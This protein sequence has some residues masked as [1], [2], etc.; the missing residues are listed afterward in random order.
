MN[1]IERK[2]K[3]LNSTNELISIFDKEIFDTFGDNTKKNLEAFN[4]DIKQELLFRVLC[5]GEFN[6]GKSTFLNNFFLQEDILP[7][8][9]IPTTAKITTIQYGE[10]RE[11]IITNQANEIVTYKD[12]IADILQQKV[13]VN[14]IDL[15]K[16]NEVKLNIPSDILKEG[17]V[18]IDT[19]GL[20]EA[21]EDRAR[22]TTEYLNKADAAIFLLNARQ[23][24]KASEKQF[25]EEFIFSKKDL[26]KIFFVINYWDTINEN[27]KEEVLEYVKEQIEKSLNKIQLKEKSLKEIELFTI[28]AKTKENFEHLEEKLFKYLS[29]KKTS[30]ILE[31][32]NV[33]LNTYIGNAISFLEEQKNQLKLKDTELEKQRKIASDDLN[34]FKNKENE[35]KNKV[36]KK[37]SIAYENFL[38]SFENKLTNIKENTKNDINRKIEQKDIEKIDKIFIKNLITQYTIENE[39]EIKRQEKVLRNAINKILDD[40]KTVLNIRNYGLFDDENLFRDSSID[41]ELEDNKTKEKALIGVGAVSG[42]TSLV[43]MIYS[44]AFPTT[45]VTQGA[46]A[47]AWAWLVGATTV[48]TGAAGLTLATGGT[49]I[50]A[51]IAIGLALYFKNDSKTN[52][53]KKL[54]E[55]VENFDDWFKRSNKNIIENLENGKDE[56]VKFVLGNIENDIITAYQNKILELDKIKELKVDSEQIEKI[57]ILLN[58]ISTLKV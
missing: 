36:G 49:A 48:S 26:D 30:E 45:I 16:T 42:A 54:Q 52:K 47:S 57:D 29:E 8:G 24:W 14:G 41:I 15:E 53:T 12:N 33:T 50:L 22:I 56:F 51:G 58:Q 23:P 35:F 46:L 43:A 6:A 38:E 25:L 28:S 17:V 19:V 5:L 44:L 31:Q 27:E 40:E 7:T 3:L 1:F 21:D 55:I 11:L 34:E 39:E 32:K 2:N 4:K 20:N 10:E 18:V 13:K 37:I 9:S